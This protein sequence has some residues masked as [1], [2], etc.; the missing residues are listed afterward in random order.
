MRLVPINCIKDGSFLAKTIYDGE[1]RILLT[2][3]AVLTD[4]IIKKAELV[5]LMSLYINDEYSS[6]EIEDIIK[7]ELRQKAV[8][9]IKDSFNNLTKYIEYGNNG[10]A[11]S[12]Y[13][14]SKARYENNEILS[15]IVSDIIDEMLSKK[16][17]LINLVDIKSMDNYTYEH[18]VNVT[19]LSL[20]LGIG[21]NM[22]KQKLFNLAMGAMLH[23]VGKVFIPKEI[24]LKNGKLTDEEFKTIKEHPEKGYEYL[25]D[26]IDISAMSR[27]IALQHHEKVDGTGYP[28]AIKEDKIHE[29]AKV[30]SIADVYDALTS[31]RPYRRAMPPNEAIE[32]L[33]AGVERSF[34][35]EM[36]KIFVR[37]IV[38]YPVG[39]LVKLSNGKTGV[40]EEIIEN[41]PLRPKVRIV[42]EGTNEYI[43]LMEENSIVIE[44]IQ[45][46]VPEKMLK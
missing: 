10:S 43:N 21:L 4:K 35:Y 45:Y 22:D 23:D 33:M 1:G 39:T 6:N 12:K 5:G 25:K 30:V 14:A 18:S 19:I 17:V 27:I 15:K 11:Q 24:L 34:D 20:V 31:D 36:V 13:E 28:E 3:G 44:G 32:Y 2:K 26:K 7:P 42:A 38:P 40:V 29:F 16:D 41:F 37:R 46:D 9:V 8:K